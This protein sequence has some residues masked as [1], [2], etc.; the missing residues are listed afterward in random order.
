[1]R[2]TKRRWNV[3]VQRATLMV[4]GRRR[5]MTVCTKCLKTMSKTR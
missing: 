1:M 4:D 5:R 2:H 3:N